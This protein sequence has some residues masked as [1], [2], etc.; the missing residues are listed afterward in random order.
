MDVALFSRMLAD[1]LF[2][3]LRK[4][5]YKYPQDFEA[6]LAA[7]RTLY[8][9]ELPLRAFDG[10]PLVYLENYAGVD[11]RT[12]KLLLRQQ[13]ER[14]GVSAA[15]EEI[16]ASSAIESIDF[17]RESIRSILKGFAPRDEAENRIL[18]QKR[19]L[20]YIADRTHA[21]TEETLHSLYQMTVGDYLRGEARLPEGAFYRNDEVFVVSDRVEHAGLAHGK[22]P[23]Y[24]GELLAFAQ[25]EDGMDELLKAAVLHYDIAYLH[26]YF[27]G[28]GRT[29]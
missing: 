24:M 17:R 29:A 15:E 22:L 1:P 9:R 18:G 6:F 2:P 16:L 8:Y 3:D 4:L 19:G 20:D 12:V 10:S 26:P 11:I 27:D 5:R 13:T 23:E 28:N 7:L 14:Y 25:T 21:I